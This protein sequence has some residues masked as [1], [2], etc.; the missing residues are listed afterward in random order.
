MLL[1]AGREGV[2][3]MLMKHAEAPLLM[4]NVDDNGSSLSLSDGREGG[5]DRN[6]VILNSIY[7]T[8]VNLGAASI[9]LQKGSAKG[10]AQAGLFVQDDKKAASLS[11]GGDNKK[12]VNIRVDQKDG[13]VGFLNE[14][15]KVIFTIP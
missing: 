7:S 2:H 10:N 5:R 1:S 8:E 3:L 4:A 9:I 14:N 15:N 12:S 11:L 6:S 13:K